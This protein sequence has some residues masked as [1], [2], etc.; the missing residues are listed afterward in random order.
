MSI[1]DKLVG[2]T[3]GHFGLHISEDSAKRGGLSSCIYI[4]C[5]NV[6]M[7]MKVIPLHLLKILLVHM[8]ELHL[9]LISVLHMPGD[10][11]V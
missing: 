1:L 11:V 3:C 9:T 2:P 6:T 7:L 8:E 4:K 10:V 5:T